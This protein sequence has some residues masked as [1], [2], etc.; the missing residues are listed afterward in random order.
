M[1]CLSKWREMALA[2]PKNAQALEEEEPLSSSDET[3]PTSARIVPKKTSSW[4]RWWR[5]SRTEPEAPSTSSTPPKERGRDMDTTKNVQDSPPRPGIIPSSSA[6]VSAG[7]SSVAFPSMRRLPDGA[8]SEP[9]SRSPSLHSGR[10]RFAKTLRLTSDQ[11]V[12]SYKD[13]G[14]FAVNVNVETTQSETGD[15][16][17]HVF[18]FG[19]WNHSLYRKHILM[20]GYG[21]SSRL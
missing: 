9:G 3:E 11:L 21:L 13:K 2:K 14:D 4:V 5:S 19:I 15:E 18:A 10:Q 20:A 17:N 1:D 7:N 6:P 16:F 8:R 12:S